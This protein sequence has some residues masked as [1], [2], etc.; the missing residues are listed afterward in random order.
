MRESLDQR[1]RGFGRSIISR[2]GAGLVDLANARQPMKLLRAQTLVCHE[3]HFLACL[4]LGVSIG[5]LG[6]V[7]LAFVMYA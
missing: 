1:D 6:A 2:V 5:V 7:A 4:C 3:K